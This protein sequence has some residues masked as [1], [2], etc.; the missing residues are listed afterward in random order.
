MEPAVNA[1][2]H[3]LVESSG[4]VRRK[5]DADRFSLYIKGVILFFSSLVTGLG[6]VAQILV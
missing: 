3:T 2:L 5:T 6:V 4:S 1:W